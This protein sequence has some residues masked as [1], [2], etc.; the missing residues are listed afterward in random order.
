M[1]SECLVWG[2]GQGDWLT[3][4]NWMKLSESYHAQEGQNKRPEQ[5]WHYALEGDAKGPMS[6]AEL[7]LELSNIRD[8]DQILV[9][10]KGMTAWADLFEFHDLLD[11]L[12]LNKREHPRAAISGSLVIA[13]EDGNTVIANL[14]TISAGGAGATNVNQMLTMGQNVTLEVKSDSLNETINVKAQV[15][16]VTEFGYVGFKFQSISME[17]KS[18]IVQYLRTA[19]VPA[20]QQ[21]A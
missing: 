10:T 14:K 12:G 13:T 9:W 20:T 4:A 11:E 18:R 7:I 17:A 5:M 1:G 19:K 8:K 16:Y 3:L 21:A 2:R 15:Q 6:R